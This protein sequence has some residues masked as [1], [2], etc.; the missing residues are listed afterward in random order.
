MG[1]EWLKR[2]LPRGLYGRA[3]L[4]LVVPVITLQLVLTLAFLQRHFEDVTSQ[5]VRSVAFE[6]NWILDEM[7]TAEGAEAALGRGR[8]IG[9]PLDISVALNGDGETTRLFYDVSGVTVTDKFFREV[10]GLDW[11]DL[12]TSIRIVRL[13]VPTPHGLAVLT[14]D[15]RR[16]SASNP[17]QLL[18]LTVFTACLMTWIAF[19]FLR[20]QLKPITLLARAAEAFG[21]GQVIDYNSSGATEIRTA[22]NAFIDMR[23]RIER[24]IEQR[25]MMLSG[26][27][28]DLRTPLTR[29]KLGLSVLDDAEAGPLRRDV[30]DMERLVEAFLDFARGDALEAAEPADPAALAR[31]AVAAAPPGGPPIDLVIEGAGEALSLRS[32]AITRAL[33]NL[34]GNAARFGNRVRVTVSH[35]PGSVSLSVEDDGPGIPEGSRAKATQAFVRLDNARNQDMGPGVGLGLAIAADTA[36]SHGGTLRLGKSES[37]GGL[38][39]EIV[40]P[41]RVVDD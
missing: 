39:A 33:G 16:V 27:S 29:L 5:M 20:N 36:H 38:K 30:D 13:G 28:H 35:P 25:T 22:G 41:R 31:A 11:V 18:V 19:L 12:G 3:A 26:V 4:I 14:L 40:L 17:H 23:S 9:S 1:F 37:L 6:V 21:K 7:R 15:R 34:I 2:Y 10:P 24:Q 8:G 32:M